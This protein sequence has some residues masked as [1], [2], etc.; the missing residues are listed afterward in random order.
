MRTRANWEQVS[1]PSGAL[2]ERTRHGV[3]KIETDRFANTDHSA[4]K[5][6]RPG[7]LI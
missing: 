5:F 7:E 2:S 6:R 4:R 3:T 1:H